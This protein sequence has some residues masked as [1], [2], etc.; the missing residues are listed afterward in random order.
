M[1]PK[2]DFSWLEAFDREMLEA[3]KDDARKTLVKIATGGDGDKALNLALVEAIHARLAQLPVKAEPKVETQ[4]IPGQTYNQYAIDC[5]SFRALIDKVPKFE[6]GREITEFISDI[7]NIFARVSIDAQA[8][9]KVQHTFVSSVMGQ[10]SSNYQ[11]DIRVYETSLDKSPVWT[12]SLFKAYLEKTY[13]TN[14]S[15][16]QV[17]QAL[18]KLQKSPTESYLDF[19]GKMELRLARVKTL[20]RA[21]VIKKY[22]D[23]TELS[24]DH[25]LSMVGGMLLLTKMESDADLMNFLTRDL[26]DCFSSRDIAKIAD[27]HVER[28]VKAPDQVLSN[29]T[30]NF[31]RSNEQCRRERFNGHCDR[32]V[33]YYRHNNARGPRNSQNRGR[34]GHGTSRGGGSRG[35]SRGGGSRGGPRGGSRGGSSRGGSSGRGTSRDRHQNSGQGRD[36]QRHANF[37]NQGDPANT[38][39]ENQPYEYPVEPQNDADFPEGSA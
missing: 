37:A 6:P 20:L 1:P 26:D 23:G 17:L 29:P 12:W 22:G 34:G 31:A 16:F 15:H 14:K 10:M 36:G 33:C 32:A 35:G 11:Q 19:S 39:D 18:E 30:V 5:A 13:E 7:D 28:R 25:V 9:A 27:K 3:T 2:H 38:D 21:H 8:D 4:V 24:A